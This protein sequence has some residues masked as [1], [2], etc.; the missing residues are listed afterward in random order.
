MRDADFWMSERM[1]FNFV[2][3]DRDDRIS[4]SEYQYYLDN[5]STLESTQSLIVIQESK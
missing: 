3:F 5:F 4:K 1:D 2:D